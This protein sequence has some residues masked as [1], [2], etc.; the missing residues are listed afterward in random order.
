MILNCDHCDRRVNS[1]TPE[2]A[3]P[4]CGLQ[5][6]F[7]EPQDNIKKR[8]APTPKDTRVAKNEERSLSNQCSVKKPSPTPEPR[9]KPYR[10]QT[11]KTNK[12]LN[13]PKTG[14]PQPEPVTCE[15]CGKLVIGIS[16]NG[17]F[18]K[19][20][21]PK[22][23]KTFMD[24]SQEIAQH[25]EME[26]LKP[27]KPEETHKTSAL[28]STSFSQCR[29]C[30]QSMKADTKSSVCP[31]CKKLLLRS[32]PTRQD[33]ETAKKIKSNTGRELN[34][35]VTNTP[36]PVAGVVRCSYCSQ[37]IN[38]QSKP[39]KYRCP[40]CGKLLVYVNNNLTAHDIGVKSKPENP[41]D[42]QL[43]SKL[44][45]NVIQNKQPNSLPIYFLP[46]IGAFLYF[47]VASTLGIFDFF[48]I[49]DLSGMQKSL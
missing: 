33:N 23:L 9:K 35:P 27:S 44:K 31:S 28:Q 14:P 34:S 26:Q 49:S 43:N 25:K 6:P 16:L 18:G 1:K 7:N 13:L 39:D 46:L 3:C 11:I 12:S 38:I 5:N 36:Q 10:G 19:I 17:K 8:V 21:C 37:R 40:N 20:R 47:M 2:Y 41:S 29:S 22:C 15:N 24:Q 4:W 45:K 32:Q 48:G 42:I 30:H